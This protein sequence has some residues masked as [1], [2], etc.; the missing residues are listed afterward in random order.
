MHYSY[1]LLSLY[2]LYTLQSY[3]MQTPHIVIYTAKMKYEVHTK[4]P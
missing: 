3:C 2:L 4:L 1:Q